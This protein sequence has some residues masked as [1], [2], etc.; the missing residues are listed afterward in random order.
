MSNAA[1]IYASRAT[2]DVGR[3]S[4]AVRVEGRRRALT[5]G[6]RSLTYCG[7]PSLGGALTTRS[8]FWNYTFFNTASGRS[9]PY[10]FQNV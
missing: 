8:A 4:V 10:S 2:N 5:I 9:M 1:A 7:Q 6:A 3:R